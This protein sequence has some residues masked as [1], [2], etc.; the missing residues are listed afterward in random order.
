MI[1]AL[2]EKK[3]RIE[4][5]PHSVAK[6]P[7]CKTPA[8]SKCGKLKIW[9]W[10][11]K[12]LKECDPWSEPESEW[13]LN[14]KKK[15]PLECREVVIGC[16]RADIVTKEGTIIELQKSSIS[17]E[18]IWE[19]ERFYRNMIWVLPA[20]KYT[21]YDVA[22]VRTRGRVWTRHHRSFDFAKKPVFIEL[23]SDGITGAFLEKHACRIQYFK[24]IK[25]IL[26]CQNHPFK[27]SELTLSNKF[28]K[29]D[30]IY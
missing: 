25:G 30:N 5:T 3:E 11:H 26:F 29:Q 22:Y 24:I 13:H 21:S 18:E 19:R 7:L 27:S 8:I 4:A 20:D 2:N 28:I 10:A 1:L 16:H 17:V 9:H 12:D 6:C 14:W 23:V 15:F